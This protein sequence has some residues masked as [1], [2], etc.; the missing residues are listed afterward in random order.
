MN[1]PKRAIVPVLLL[2]L[3][4]FGYQ[5]A[6]F[7]ADGADSAK[8]N[9]QAT[10]DTAAAEASIPAEPIPVQLPDPAQDLNPKKS[11]K[12]GGWLFGPVNRLEAEVINLEKRLDLLTIPLDKLEP[13]TIALDQDMEGIKAQTAVLLKQLT[14]M[15]DSIKG[16]QT[17]ITTLQGPIS[18]LK[19]PVSALREPVNS[20]RVPISNLAEPVAGLR[21]PV[22]QLRLPL[23]E[24][25]ANV[26][27]LQGPL[28]SLDQRIVGLGPRFTD[29]DG[30]FVGLNSRFTN[31]DGR[32]INLDKRFESLDTRLVA[33]TREMASLQSILSLLVVALISAIVFAVSLV[34]YTIVNNRPKTVIMKEYLHGNAKV[35]EPEVARPRR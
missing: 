12:G 32:F 28:K 33:L 5:S 4:F 13:G 14:G 1:K 7:A 23:I 25:N 18:D 35:E 6:S 22:V 9:P 31:L 3:S 11:E 15:Q 27:R 10:A 16:L 24:A 34:V 29:L 8:S 21:G 20:L 2:S 19:E 17:E 30:R 26:A